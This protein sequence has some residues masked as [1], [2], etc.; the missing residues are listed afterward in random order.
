MVVRLRGYHG[1]NLNFFK[2]GMGAP[3][4]LSTKRDGI[5]GFGFYKTSRCS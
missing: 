3:V 5:I 2:Q 4:K 1:D